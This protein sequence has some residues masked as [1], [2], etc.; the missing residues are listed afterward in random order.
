LLAQLNYNN[1]ETIEMK[2]NTLAKSLTLTAGALGMMVLVP[3]ANIAMAQTSGA[4]PDVIDLSVD[5]NQDGVSDELLS[6]MEK[7]IVTE[8]EW[9]KRVEAAGLNSDGTY[10]E[11]AY[12]EYTAAITEAN[13]ELEARLPWSDNA[14]Q[15]LA[16]GFELAE[17]YE[18]YTNSSWGEGGPE[19]TA[20][21]ERMVL[22]G[23]LRDQ[24]PSIVAVLE[25]QTKVYEFLGPQY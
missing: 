15:M 25:A 16:L 24:E 17:Q 3:F 9:F 2:L 19:Q 18:Q 6:A 13:M 23:N 10:N 22:E 21:E 14:R 4:S 8:A 5:V 7:V 11:Q 12:E 20:L 1:L